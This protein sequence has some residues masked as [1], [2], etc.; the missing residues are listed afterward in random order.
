MSPTQ[1]HDKISHENKSCAQVMK[2]AVSCRRKAIT[3]LSS[4][5]VAAGL[6]RGEPIQDT[7]VGTLLRTA[8]PVAG[9]IATGCALYQYIT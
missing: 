3:F 7:E 6:E 5:A 8:F 4:I 2:L 9:S 1:Y